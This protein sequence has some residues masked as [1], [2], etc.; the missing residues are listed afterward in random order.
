MRKGFSI[1]FIAVFILLI[2]PLSLMAC[3]W[4]ERTN[5]DT[6]PMTSVIAESGQSTDKAR[7]DRSRISD[8]SSGAILDLGSRDDSQNN[9]LNYNKK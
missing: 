2:T 5:S 1:S 3:Q 7:T 8:I 4:L 6:A 9:T